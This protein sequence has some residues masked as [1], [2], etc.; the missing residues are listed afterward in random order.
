[1]FKIIKPECYVRDDV[2]MCVY[3]TV[4]VKIG[5]MDKA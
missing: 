1:M 2:F 5:K 3:T 4:T